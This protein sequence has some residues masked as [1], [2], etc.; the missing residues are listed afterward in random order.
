M[1]TASVSAVNGILFFYPLQSCLRVSQTEELLYWS[2]VPI[3]Q[4]L[5]AA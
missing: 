3:G 2:V 5:H 1:I 4:L